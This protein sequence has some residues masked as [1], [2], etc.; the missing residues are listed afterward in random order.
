VESNTFWKDVDLTPNRF[1][2]STRTVA[3][4]DGRLTLDQGAAVEKATRI[5]H[6]EIKT[7]P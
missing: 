7:R 6:V 1:L 3:V 5:T 4:R 2:T